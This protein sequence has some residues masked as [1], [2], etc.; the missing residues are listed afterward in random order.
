MS[1]IAFPSYASLY[2]SLQHDGRELA[3]ATGF[4]VATSDHRVGLA[5][6][7]HNFTGR[8]LAG[9]FRDPGQAVPTSVVIRHTDTEL[10]WV[11]VP[12]PLYTEGSPVDGRTAWVDD[13]VSDVAF[14]PFHSVFKQPMYLCYPVPEVGTPANLPECD[15]AD[16]VSIVGFPFGM[17][18]G[19]SLGVW[20]RGTVASEPSVPYDDHRIFLVD[21][22]TRPGQS[23]SP[24]I[25]YSSSGII[26]TSDGRMLFG[27]GPYLDLLGIYVGRTDDQS[28]LGRVWHASVLWPL[29]WEAFGLV[30]NQDRHR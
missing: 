16:D 28:D 18:A 19:G 25:K 23:G 27:E 12:Y 11:D 3:R 10:N 30:E 14:L 6:A 22:R 21:S 15:V 5:T 7:L 2:L 20:S 13:G 24:V 1:Q 4:M 17:N 8:D 26:N 9:R 29:V